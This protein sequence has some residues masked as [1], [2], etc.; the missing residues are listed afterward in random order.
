MP[1]SGN[2]K[3]TTQVGKLV[4][5]YLTALKRQPEAGLIIIEDDSLRTSLLSCL[6][7]FGLKESQTWSEIMENLAKGENT[8]VQLEAPLDEE[9]YEIIAQYYRRGGTIQM[10][11]DDLRSV[12]RVDFEPFETHLLLVSDRE[13][14]HQI[15]KEYSIRDKVGIIESIS[16]FQHS[17]RVVG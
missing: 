12:K 14:L 9:L 1:P 5:S 10:Y 13:A 17:R 3:N 8:F 15:E 11:R 6:E 4:R 2:Q 16:D 7:K